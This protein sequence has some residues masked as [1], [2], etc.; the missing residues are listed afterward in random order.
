[1][2]VD[3]DDIDGPPNAAWTDILT[4]CGGWTRTVCVLSGSGRSMHWYY[5]LPQGVVVG[6]TASRLAP[7]IDTRGERG[8][9]ICPPSIHRDT[10]QPY[11]WI[12]SPGDGLVAAIPKRLLERLV[13]AAG[14]LKPSRSARPKIVMATCS[15]RAALRVLAA[16]CER[17]ATAIPGMRNHTAFQASAAIGNLV[18]AGELVFHVAADALRDAA[19]ASGLPLTEAETVV[20]N[21]L[22]RGMTTP[23]AI[24]TGP[25]R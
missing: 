4:E 3:V 23:R 24:R 5:R 20:L 17:I 1:L 6:N 8:Y 25:A 21:G 7:G 18:A 14:Q 19:L 12:V 16:E 15:G 2:V 22:R 13:D 11:Q 10:G 9:V